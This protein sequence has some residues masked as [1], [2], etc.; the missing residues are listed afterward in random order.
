[1]A[2]CTETTRSPPTAMRKL[3]PIVLG[4]NCEAAATSCV[5]L[6]GG[7]SARLL[8]RI[9]ACVS[10]SSSSSAAVPSFV[11]RLGRRDAVQLLVVCVERRRIVDAPRKQDAAAVSM[12][13]R[14]LTPENL[15][16]C[17]IDLHLRKVGR[18]TD[19]LPSEPVDDEI[20]DLGRALN[21]H[22]WRFQDLPSCVQGFVRPAA[23]APR[24]RRTGK[25]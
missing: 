20:A 1:M 25:A 5:S 8:S 24:P 9:S 2:H 10:P 11:N 17:R 12:P 7:A 16:S 15:F 18:G 3:T 13:G 6:S 23:V 21:L 14:I 22:A 4:R 19:H